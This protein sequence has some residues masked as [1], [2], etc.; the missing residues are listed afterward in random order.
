MTC[1]II[2]FTK[3]LPPRLYSSFYKQRLFYIVYW[4]LFRTLCLFWEGG[5]KI[6]WQNI[7]NMAWK[8]PIFYDLWNIILYKL[9]YT[10][11]NI[12]IIMEKISYQIFVEKTFFMVRLSHTVQCSY[13][14]PIFLKR[15]TEGD[16]WNIWQ[17]CNNF[18]VD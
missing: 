2:V 11:K 15:Q 14:F 1:F 5:I 16:T 17:N 9:Y 8:H 12:V 7:C 3:K 6:C 18:V 13:Q 10:E 4:I